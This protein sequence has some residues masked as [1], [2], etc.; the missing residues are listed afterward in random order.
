MYGIGAYRN[1]N[2]RSRII[3][4]TTYICFHVNVKNASLLVCAP[5]FDLFITYIKF[6][7]DTNYG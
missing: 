7:T 1:I 3:L 2:A 4:D 5:N 6:I